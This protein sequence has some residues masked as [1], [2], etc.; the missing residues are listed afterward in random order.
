MIRKDRRD[1]KSKKTKKDKEKK[2]RKKLKK[3]LKKLAKLDPKIVTTPETSTPRNVMVLSNPHGIIKPG[4]S[5]NNSI[6]LEIA[7]NMQQQ[8]QP[9]LRLLPHQPQQMP[10][11]IILQAQQTQAPTPQPTQVPTSQ[12][13]TSPTPPL[14]IAVTHQEPPRTITP[15]VSLT[16]KKSGCKLCGGHFERL[17]IQK[18]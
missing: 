8:S 5:Q 14:P 7:Q 16:T 9:S 15:N 1:K 10:H 4:S 12:A 17:L 13:S 18:K 3:H 11:S 6:L 2:D